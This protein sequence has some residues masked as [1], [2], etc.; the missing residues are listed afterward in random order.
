MYGCCVVVWTSH[1]E[2]L[3]GVWGG[4]K[5]RWVAHRVRADSNRFDAL[6]F[7]RCPPGVTRHGWRDRVA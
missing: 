5:R 3:S 6:G 4:V 1:A 7:M 2:V